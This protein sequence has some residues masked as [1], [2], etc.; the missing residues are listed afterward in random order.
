MARKL[1]F[2]ALALALA[3]PVAAQTAT[4][5][6]SPTPTATFTPV[7]VGP[8]VLS[9]SGITSFIGSNQTYWAASTNASEDHADY[10]LPFD[11]VIKN[12]T[13]GCVGPN[14][15]PVSH[16]FRLRVGGVNSSL[17]AVLP[18]TTATTIQDWTHT[19]GTIA[20]GT[21]FAFAEKPSAVSGVSMRCAISVQVTSAIGG[22]YHSV[23][24]IGGGAN[25]DA[26]NPND[27]AFCGPGPP[28]GDAQI[29]G[30]ATERDASWINASS[31][32]ITG[33]GVVSDQTVL[34]GRTET[35]TVRNVT[36]ACDSTVAVT[37]GEADN[38]AI[39]STCTGGCCTFAAGDE[40]VVRYNQTGDE[41][42][43]NRRI[44][45]T[46]TAA[47]GFQVLGDPITYEG[48]RRAIP[49]GG[50]WGPS[51]GYVWRAPM[52]FGIRTIW[53]RTKAAVGKSFQWAACPGN[54]TSTTGVCGGTRC[55]TATGASSCTGS[56][57]G[58]QYQNVFQGQSLN[59]SLLEDVSA[60]GT[61]GGQAPAAALQMDVLL[62]TTTPTPTATAATPT[63]TRTATP[64]VTRTATPSATRTATRTPTPVPTATGR[65]RCS[66]CQPELFGVPVP[67]STPCATCETCAA[68]C[69]LPH[70]CQG[71]PETEEFAC[72]IEDFGEGCP[73]SVA[74]CEDEGGT[75]TA[76][77]VASCRTLPFGCIVGASGCAADE[78]ECL[79]F[80]GHTFTVDADTF[81]AFNSCTCVSVQCVE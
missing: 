20:A 26:M 19:S 76:D 81:C 30:G 35:Y 60:S 1:L 57:N 54:S 73:Q 61:T 25:G 52:D 66:H 3:G 23:V 7:P 78:A 50:T 77:A 46:T 8:S 6:T 44:S 41:Q 55:T 22:P 43:M 74:A 59:L 69:S 56:F 17:V 62:P 18:G 53:V 42:V 68:A 65:R 63:P 58:L 24:L 2:L 4:P 64:T 29:C 33:I 70:C 72:T 37:R 80:H 47:S 40:L 14:V 27:G 38:E 21:R 5:T 51:T 67:T 13:V 34:A 39:H 48:D 31:G 49:N 10:V 28:A 75:V 12:L 11:A 71:S 15:G 32:R 9:V 79:T 36:A 16:T 45:V